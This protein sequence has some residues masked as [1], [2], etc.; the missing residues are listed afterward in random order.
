MTDKEFSEELKKFGEQMRW[1]KRRRLIRES[2]REKNITYNKTPIELYTN[3]SD[4]LN[5][6]DELH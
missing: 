2:K 4:I 3:L 5:Y 1:D 6:P